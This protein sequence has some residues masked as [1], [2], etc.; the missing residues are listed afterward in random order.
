MNR[1][2]FLKQLIGGL[3]IVSLPIKPKPAEPKSVG[4]LAAVADEIREPDEVQAE[5][6]YEHGLYQINQS[7]GE[8]KVI[9]PPKGTPDSLIGAKPA[10]KRA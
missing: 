9:V 4:E 7:T 6:P 10:R 3:A 2:G 5:E 1:K 8:C